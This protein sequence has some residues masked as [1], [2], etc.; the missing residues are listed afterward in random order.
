MNDKQFPDR[1]FFMSLAALSYIGDIRFTL[2]SENKNKIENIVQ[3]NYENFC[4]LY[5]K[6]FNMEPFNKLC[7]YEEE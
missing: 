4:K 2:R 3:G 7:V 1:A 6:V 5:S